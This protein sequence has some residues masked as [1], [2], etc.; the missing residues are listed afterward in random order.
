MFTRQE[1]A[2]RSMISLARKMGVA[3]VVH[4]KAK[5]NYEVAMARL[6]QKTVREME[7]SGQGAA[8][9]KTRARAIKRDLSVK[10]EV[11]PHRHTRGDR[12]CEECRALAVDM[13]HRHSQTKVP[14][15]I[16]GPSKLVLR[17]LKY[18]NEEAF[19]RYVEDLEEE[20]EFFEQY[21]EFLP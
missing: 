21:Q 15:C 4:E 17:E 2:T 9:G 5:P 13:V 11:D 16:L 8:K 18:N 12:D 1:I 3:H 14:E 6:S 19:T 20:M 7:G 10:I